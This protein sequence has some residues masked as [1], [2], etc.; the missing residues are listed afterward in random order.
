MSPKIL[1]SKA[2]RLWRERR[3]PSVSF[4]VSRAVKR[5]RERTWR[6]YDMLSVVS[7]NPPVLLSGCHPSKLAVYLQPQLA[8]L[9]LTIFYRA[10]WTMEDEP[11]RMDRVAAIKD[12]QARFPRHRYILAAAT[13]REVELVSSSGVR[14][15]F[16]NE[17]AFIDEHSFVPGAADN[18]V[19]DAVLDAQIAPYKRLELAAAVPS[20]LVLTYV[21]EG[22]FTP[23][24]GERIRSLLAHATWA[25]GNFWDASYRRLNRRQVADWYKK[26][27]VGLCLSA[28]EGPNLGS[29]QYLLADLPVVSTPSLG[30]RDEFFSDD[31]AAIVDAEPA[32]VAAAVAKF[33][34]NRP[35]ALSIRRRT[36]EK[37]YSFR[38][39]FGD[40]LVRDCGHAA[41]DEAWWRE[42]TTNRP[43]AYQDLK[44]V[45][46]LLRAA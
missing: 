5:H 23:A 15:E 27:R 21:Y 11:S 4:W 26:A 42:F 36:L 30:G 39:R 28:L 3:L 25:N 6:S 44:K 18:Q 22:R 37:I 45:A 20:L 16:L 19:F 31:C 1:L 41:L 46:A 34:R 40:I 8:G 17:N 14:A 12:A 2:L 32:A 9:D 29:I 7:V 10:G 35:P 33:V 13:L 24:Y 43:I 38:R